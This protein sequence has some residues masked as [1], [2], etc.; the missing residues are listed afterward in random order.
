MLI[1]P[2]LPCLES[3]ISVSFV[4]SRCATAFCRAIPAG[5][6]AFDGAKV[7][8]PDCLGFASA[9]GLRRVRGGGGGYFCLAEVVVGLGSAVGFRNI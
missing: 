7:E 3:P 5:P 6:G 1:N 2:R 8:L 9:R 4:Q